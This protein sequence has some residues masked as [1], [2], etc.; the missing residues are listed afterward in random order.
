[1]I[2]EIVVLGRGGQGGVTGAQII[3]EAAYYSKNYKDVA[4]SPTFG[5]ERRGSAVFAFTRIADEKIWTRQNIYNPN[6][7]IILD[8]T[9]LTASFI[10]SIKPN[11]ILIINTDK[12]ANEMIKKYGITDDI[13]V[14]V[15]NVTHF[16]YANNL[17][18]DGQPMV[19][20]PI[21]GI[22]PK[23]MKTIPMESLKK[24]IIERFGDRKS[25]LNI[26]VAELSA[27]AVDIRVG[28]K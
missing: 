2:T 9:I 13:T 23:V 4:S 12:C 20:A 3:A 28:G 7:A 6:V 25:E 16:C 11:G 15:S 19:S 14:A 18:V 21:L 8:E 22:I 26:K 5:T 17:I 27:E 24:V 1:M 10:K